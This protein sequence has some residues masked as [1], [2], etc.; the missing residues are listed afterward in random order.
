MDEERVNQA[1][2]DCMD[3]CRGSD[4]PLT[5]VAEFLAGLKSAGWRRDEIRLVE[6]PVHKI[7]HALVDT[8]RMPREDTAEE[9]DQ[10]K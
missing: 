6:L 2:R 10:I 9:H 1:I 8:E 5:Q 4:S 7:L 3:N